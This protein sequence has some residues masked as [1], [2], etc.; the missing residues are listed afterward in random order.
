[1]P[2]K[3]TKMQAIAPDS[4]A[5]NTPVR[6]PTR[7]LAGASRAQMAVTNSLPTR[8]MLNLS[9]TGRLYYLQ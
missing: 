7:M 5:V 9:P 4:V 8:L 6:M 1:M 3:T 2:M